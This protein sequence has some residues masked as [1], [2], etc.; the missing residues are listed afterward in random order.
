MDLGDVL[1][2]YR[3]APEPDDCEHVPLLRGG[4][5]S[6]GT[7]VSLWQCAECGRSIVKEHKRASDGDVLFPGWNAPEQPGMV[8]R[9]RDRFIG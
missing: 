3:D 2:H 8:D 5:K 6:G 1:E 4:G 7:I 9:V